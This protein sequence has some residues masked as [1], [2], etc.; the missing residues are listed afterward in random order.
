MIPP[1]KSSALF[2]V[3]LLVVTVL[4][5]VESLNLS[6]ASRAAP[7]QVLVPTLLLLMVRLGLDLRGDADPLAIGRGQRSAAGVEAGTAPVAGVTVGGAPWLRVGAGRWRSLRIAGWIGLL[8]GLV[9][10]LGFFA[11]VPLFLLG[12]LRLE[13][14]VGWWGGLAFAAI[15]AGAI[16]MI[17]GVLVN[18]PF[19]EPALPR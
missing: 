19:P 7:I 5:L 1:G 2:T 4:L 9:Y 12:Y 14:E 8:T 10:L 18:L 13:T 6:D 17:F 11:A 16:Y 3:G 15:V